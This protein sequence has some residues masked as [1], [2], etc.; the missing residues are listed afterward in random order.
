MRL[1]ALLTSAV[2]VACAAA[3]PFEARAS[4][5]QHEAAGAEAGAMVPLVEVMAR[6]AGIADTVAAAKWGTPQPI[7]DPTREKTVLDNAAAQAPR[8]GVDPALAV[9]VFSDQI[10]ANKVVQYG[11]FSRWTAHPNQAPATRPDLTQVRPVLDQIGSELLTQLRTTETIRAD[12]HCVGHLQAA[13]V[14]VERS[15]HLDRLHREA[16]HRAVTSVCG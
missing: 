1:P 8:F 10:A 9:Q 2:L 15:Q 16:L 4:A 6:R 7:D 3:L 12:E 13:Q 14:Q 5:N 11:L